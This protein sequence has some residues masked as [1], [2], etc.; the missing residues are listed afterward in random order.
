[1]K[2]LFKRVFR[3]GLNVSQALAEVEDEAWG[4]VAREMLDFIRGAKKRGVC[5][6]HGS[7]PGGSPDEAE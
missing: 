2:R 3:S 1:L 7:K 5:L 6:A 4:P